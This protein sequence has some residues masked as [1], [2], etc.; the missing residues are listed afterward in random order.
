M[1]FA[2]FKVCFK[3][4]Q[5]NLKRYPDDKLPIFQCAGCLGFNNGH[6]IRGEFLKEF[7]I[8]TERY[9]LNPEPIVTEDFRMYFNIYI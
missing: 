8:I 4:L 6:F 7:G 1:D 3:Y 9:R 5:T 2:S